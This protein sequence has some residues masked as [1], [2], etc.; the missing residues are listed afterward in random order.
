MLNREAVKRC[1]EKFEPLRPLLPTGTKLLYEFFITPDESATSED[2]VF[3]LVTQSGGQFSRYDVLTELHIHYNLGQDKDYELNKVRQW[4]EEYRKGIKLKY[5]HY[6][7]FV[8]KTILLDGLP[9]FLP[10]GEVK[11]A[12]FGGENIFS[13]L[14]SNS[15]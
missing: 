5:F 8:I 4:L 13:E 2:G 7:R 3:L 15:L 12:E 10:N 14:L 9:R 6:R 11:Q 1:Q